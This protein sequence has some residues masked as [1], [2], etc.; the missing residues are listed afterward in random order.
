MRCCVFTAL[1][2]ITSCLC[3]VL[4]AADPAEQPG[5]M[6]LFPPRQM[7]LTLQ[8]ITSDMLNRQT[9][10]HCEF[11]FMKTS[12]TK[13]QTLIPSSSTA[14]TRVLSKIS[15]TTQEPFSN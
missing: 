12:R 2:L 4:L 10:F 14:G 8:L 6:D 13:Q 7:V 3:T 1:V 9:R 11:L 5:A 15:I